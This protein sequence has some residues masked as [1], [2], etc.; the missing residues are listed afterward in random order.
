M[1]IRPYRPEDCEEMAQL[2]Y[3]TVHTI[4]IKD[5]T[6]EQL[7]AWADGK[8]ELDKWNRSFLQ[9]YTLVAVE[10]GH[11]MGFGDIT[12]QGYLDRLF[13]HRAFQNHGIGSALCSRLECWP[14]TEHITVH[15]SI[16]ARPFFERRGY[17]VLQ[18]RKAIRAG[19]GL[20]YYVMEK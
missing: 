9:N 1:Q 15:A 11:I 7:C 6:S 16:T 3:D 20:I 10:D 12:P 19:V 4:C 2:F 8:I 17:R 18:K 5:Y 13:V 14:D